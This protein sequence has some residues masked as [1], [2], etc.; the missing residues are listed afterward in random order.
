MSILLHPQYCY[1]H[2]KYAESLLVH[3]VKT[4]AKLYGSQYITHNFH[5]LTHIADD[6]LTFGPLD[7]C[8]AFKFENF[9]QQFKKCIRKG[10]KPLQQLVKRLSE[11]SN[12]DSCFSDS[13]FHVNSP[14]F[15]SHHFCGPL[16]AGCDAFQ[17]YRILQ[18]QSFK[19][20]TTHPNSTCFLK[21]GKVVVVS[22]IVFS[23]VSQEF[24][25]YALVKFLDESDAP[26]IVCSHWINKFQNVC[27]YPNVRTNEARDKLLRKCADPGQDWSSCRIKILHNYGS[28]SA[29]YKHLRQAEETSNLE[30]EDEILNKRPRK[31]TKMHLMYPGEESDEDCTQIISQKSTRNSDL[32][33][34]P[35]PPR[36]PSPTFDR[37]PASPCSISLIPTTVGGPS[38]LEKTPSSHSNKR[39]AVSSSQTIVNGKLVAWMAD[40]SVKVQQL[41]DKMDVMLQNQEKILLQHQQKVPE[42]YESIENLETLGSLPICDDDSFIEFDL[43]ISQ[44]SH[45]QRL[46]IKVLVSV[47]GKDMRC[48]IHNMLR[49]VLSDEVAELYT[50]SGKSTI[51]DVIKKPFLA[52]EFLKSIF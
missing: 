5:G 32:T 51:K 48:H 4:C 7:S 13:S 36:D 46:L 42:R 37:S 43:K 39:A 38:Q 33:P 19:I 22:N 44:D 24:N 52:T 45:F 21:D 10:D 12:S 25:M 2:L 47:G 3:F 50:I 27:L 17:Q 1:K 6:V 11:M 9:M 8:S 16:S 26:G 20:T 41:Q 29:A 15:S 14:T 28:F 31:K 49:R 30:S 35:V 40:I 18:F 34:Y 23:N